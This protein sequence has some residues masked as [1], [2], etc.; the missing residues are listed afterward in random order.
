MNK[1][2]TSLLKKQWSKIK[3]LNNLSLKEF[4]GSLTKYEIIQNI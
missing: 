2:L 1:I 3:N 4:I